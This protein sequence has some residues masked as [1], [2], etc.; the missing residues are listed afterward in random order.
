MHGGSR[1]A[2]ERVQQ[3]AADWQW[4]D[5]AT[6]Q[7]PLVSI[8]AVKGGDEFEAGRPD[9]GIAVRIRCAWENTTQG[10]PKRPIAELVKLVMDGRPAD[11][12]LVARRRPRGEG[13]ED[14]YYVVH[15]PDPMPGRHTAEATVRRIDDRQEST[16]QMEFTV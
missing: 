10:Q 2:V 15:L 3:H 4:W 5:N 6:I 11:P 12:V 7:R 9:R 1:E 8:V 16:V 14:H 13:L